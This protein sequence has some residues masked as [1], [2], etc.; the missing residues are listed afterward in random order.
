MKNN[1]SL[2]DFCA[3]KKKQKPQKTKQK[4]PKNQ[5]KRQEQWLSQW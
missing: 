2:K 5:S 3:K 1:L 4:N